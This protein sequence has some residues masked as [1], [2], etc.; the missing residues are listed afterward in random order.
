MKCKWNTYNVSF[1][2]VRVFIVQKQISEHL[3]FCCSKSS[4]YPCAPP[5]TPRATR[6]SE[7]E[8]SEGDNLVHIA[9]LLVDK[10]SPEYTEKY[11]E[12]GG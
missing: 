8:D 3:K 7:T 12:V 10:N 4:E 5:P 6:S 11:N 9:V 2:T 1:L